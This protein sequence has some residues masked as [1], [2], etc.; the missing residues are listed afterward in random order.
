MGEEGVEQ[1][2]NVTETE[3]EPVNMDIVRKKITNTTAKVKN[4]LVTRDLVDFKQNFHLV[5]S[6]EPGSLSKPRSQE[7]L[8]QST[9]F[10]KVTK[11][12]RGKAVDFWFLGV[13]PEFRGN[14]IANYLTKAVIPLVKAAGYKY[15]TIEA[16]SA[17]TSKSAAWNGFTAVHEVQAK[18]WEWKGAPLYTN[19]EPPHGTWTFWVK[20]LQE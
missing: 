18:D 13:H 10:T 16:T 8:V 17:F 11:K 2:E 20:N 4:D 1:S 7:C 6:P 19:A 3:S 15:A 5:S 9:E 14:K 12:H